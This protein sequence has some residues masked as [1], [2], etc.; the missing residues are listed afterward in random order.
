MTGDALWRALGTRSDRAAGGSCTKGVLAVA[1]AVAAVA[2]APRETEACSACG[3]TLSS[4]WAAQGFATGSGFRLDLRFDYLNQDELR[5]GTGTVD[6]SSIT[7]PNDREIQQKTIN[8]NVSLA[9]DYSPD[10]AWGVNIQ[11]PFLD[12][13][14]TTI[15]PGDTEISTSDFSRIGDARIIGR[16]QGFFP[17][18]ATGVQLGVK[19]AT[20]TFDENFASGPQAGTP[21]DRGLQPGTGTTDVIL[22]AYHY[23]SLAP[24]WSYFAQAVVEQPFGSRD[25]FKPGTALNVNLGARWAATR[26]IVPQIQLNVRAEGRETGPNADTPNSGA[27]LAYL[28][29]GITVSV[30]RGVQAFGFVQ[31]PVYQNVNGY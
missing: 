2:A 1:L 30:V 28:G 9:F 8:R 24:R 21:V 25:G 14:H 7:F 29:P 13:Y 27:T 10:A 18:H 12:R 17:D 16:Y 20:G 11:V 5:S 3:C 23:G 26:G 15:A 4:D 19:I 6:R 22:G 31:F